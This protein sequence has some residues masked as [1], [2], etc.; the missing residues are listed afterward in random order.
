MNARADK[1]CVLFGGLSCS[2]QHQHD[3]TNAYY[4]F[5]LPTETTLVMIDAYCSAYKL[6][7]KK[8]MSLYRSGDRQPLLNDN[9]FSSSTPFV[10]RTD[11]VT[12]LR[13]FFSWT[14][15]S[16]THIQPHTVLHI[17]QCPKIFFIESSQLTYHHK[18]RSSRRLC[19]RSCRVQRSPKL[20][21]CWA[22]L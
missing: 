17:F 7:D 18:P 10:W 2:L 8:F 19:L 22:R 5:F 15:N 3:H 11:C 16:H 20:H 6:F 14:L 12:C 9:S 13:S 4:S 1:S 21:R